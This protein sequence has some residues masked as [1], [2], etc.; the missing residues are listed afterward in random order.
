MAAGDLTL[1]EEFADQL[2]NKVHNFASDTIKVA[3]INNTTVPTAGDATP[4]KSDYTECSAGGNYTAGG[5]TM[6]V[7][8]SE[9][10]GVSTIDFTSNISMASN[11]SNPTDVYYGLIYNDTDA[12]D[13]AIGFVEIAASGANGT[14]G[15]ISVTWGANVFTVTVN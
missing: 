11:G 7:T 5:F 8:E 15:L 13:T 4:T 9:S 6:T 14:A 2:T 1:F 10:G 12:S 3:F